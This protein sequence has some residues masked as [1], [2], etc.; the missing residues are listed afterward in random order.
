MQPA[1]DEGSGE[2]GG[3]PPH[4]DDAAQP[5]TTRSNEE[6]H[7]GR[8]LGSRTQRGADLARLSATTGAGYVGA[9]LRGLRDADAETA[10]HAASAERISEVLGQMKGAAMKLG[11]LASFVDLDVP[12]EI[13]DAYQ[14]VLAQLRDHA[15]AADPDAIESVV[16]DEYGAPPDEVFAWW[17]HEPLAVASIGQVHRARLP[18]GTDVVAKV[19]YP[20]VAEA[21]EADLANAGT[22]APLARIISPNLQVRPLL[23]EMRD[24]L[25]DELDY[26]REAQYQ[27][28]FAVR[29]DGHPFI[30]V[31]RVF[32][33]WCRPRVLVNEYVAGRD[34]DTM[35]AEADV[36]ERRRYGEIVFRFV[37]GSLYRFR[38][39]NADP[40]PG[41][42]LFPTSGPDAGSVVFL[43]FGSV[44]LFR[45][46]A[47]D[48]LIDTLTATIAGD[49]ERLFDLLSRAGFV[50]RGAHVD[51]DKLFAWFATI[52]APILEDAEWTFTP[53][54]AR[55]V[56][57]TVTDPRAGYID[58]LR[59]LNLPA[60]YL[61]LHR[62]QLGVNSILG[63][64]GAR[65]NW[66]RIMGELW[67]GAAPS[68][69][70]GALERP[71]IDAS[72]HLA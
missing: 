71:F 9:R 53:D 21:I 44:K 40:H 50:P 41:N 62:I 6:G 64:L 20:G 37:Y 54:F 55:E 52:H 5:A 13:A 24:R 33:Q 66:Q 28:A 48:T 59:R 69:E 2:A 45:S 43:D 27:Q 57:R 17:E 61:L 7:H 11:Q 23:E 70:L 22:L 56:I 12:P 26:Q 18:D 8:G 49:S 16:T 36:E 63:R 39:F 65:A 19:Q 38:L 67:D 72:P 30:R 58:L 35:M 68:T 60:E 29:Y 46:Q 25:V 14:D 47:R 1:S 32:P 10:F 3:P 15:P 51:P 31:P 34:F 42:Y 4:H